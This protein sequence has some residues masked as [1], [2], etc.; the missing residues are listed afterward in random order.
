M[1]GALKWLLV[2][3]KVR[4]DRR[5]RLVMSRVQGLSWPQ[6]ASLIAALARDPRLPW[7]VRLVP[8]LV[9]AYI[10]SPLDLIPDFVPLIGQ[11]DDIA[12]LGLAFRFAERA[13]PPGLIEEHLRRVSERAPQRP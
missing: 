9:A 6:R 12:V 4:R 1:L 7:R 2:V 8:F 3:W 13:M 10:A 5:M 11:L